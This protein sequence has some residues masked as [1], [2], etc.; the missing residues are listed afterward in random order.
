MKQLFIFLSLPRMRRVYLSSD[1]SIYKSS[2]P[3]YC[4]RCYRLSIVTHGIYSL[5]ILHPL[6]TPPNP[7]LIPSPPPQPRK[8]DSKSYNDPP[9]LP[10]ATRPA[11]LS[12]VL[13]QTVVSPLLLLPECSSPQW[14]FAE[15]FLLA[16]LRCRGVID[17]DYDTRG[18]N[19]SKLMG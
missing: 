7:T 19:T 4:Q 9:Q 3:R 16:E 15:G 13:S 12:A 17:R 18:N 6:Q 2:H 11:H 8:L 10:S 1:L 5:H 14:W